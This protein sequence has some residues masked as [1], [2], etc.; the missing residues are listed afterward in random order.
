MLNQVQLNQKLL[1][2][3]S[4]RKKAQMMRVIHT[5]TRIRTLKTPTITATTTVI[6]ILRKLLAQTEKTTIVQV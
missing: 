4:N 1:K 3:N 2:L 6:A 5:A